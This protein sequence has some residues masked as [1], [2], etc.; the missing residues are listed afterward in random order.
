M[1][2]ISS[3]IILFLLFSIS[4]LTYAI[5]AYAAVSIS[6]PNGVN[7]GQNFDVTVSDANVTVD[8]PELRV[9]NASGKEI[10]CYLSSTNTTFKVQTPSTGTSITL[11]VVKG[12]KSNTALR[13]VCNHP[14]SPTVLQQK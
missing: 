10:S 2:R 13:S 7:I 14:P 9:L 6:A 12:T 8:W 5:P 4:Q 11:Q 3:T 1:K